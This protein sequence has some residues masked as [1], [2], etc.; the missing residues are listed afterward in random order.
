MKIIKLNEKDKPSF[1][2]KLSRY[3]TDFL[4]TKV[5]FLEVTDELLL[6]EC[7]MKPKNKV[8]SQYVV[9]FLTDAAAEKGVVIKNKIKK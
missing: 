9:K 2:M 3:L 7:G 5:S 4:N 1:C 6:Y 8:L